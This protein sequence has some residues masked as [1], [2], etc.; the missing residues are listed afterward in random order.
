MSKQ[1]PFWQSQTNEFDT[2]VMREQIQQDATEKL[3][4]QNVGDAAAFE[5]NYYNL[6][7]AVD[8]TFVNPYEHHERPL[9]ELGIDHCEPL[10]P[11][12]LPYFGVKTGDGVDPLPPIVQHK[13]YS[14]Y[15]A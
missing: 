9:Q 13:R 5:K 7:K 4:F 2:P 10:N 11:R 14:C 8:G 3:G 6:T 12:I 1:T 15:G